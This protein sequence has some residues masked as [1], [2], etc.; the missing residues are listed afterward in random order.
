MQ[1]LIEVTLEDGTRLL[2]EPSDGERDELVEAGV[3]DHITT[4]RD[5]FQTMMSRLRP[6]IQTVTDQV[7]SLPR[8]P[9]K[10]TVEIGIKI[11]AESGVVIAKAASEG[12]LT[13][14]MEWSGPE[15][16]PVPGQRQSGE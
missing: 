15:R 13:L 4:A 11:T 7:S 3:G 5:S 16:G 2:V 9:D 10:F 6:V 14:T 12:H 1:P 8:R